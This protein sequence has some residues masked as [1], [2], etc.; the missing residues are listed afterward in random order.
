MVKW[1][2]RLVWRFKRRGVIR[3][4]ADLVRAQLATRGFPECPAHGGSIRCDAADEQVGKLVE[5]IRLEQDWLDSA[6]TQIE[7]KDEVDRIRGRRQHL[8]ER[9]TLLLPMLE[10]VYVDTNEEKRVV[11]IKPKA[12]FSRSSR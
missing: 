12:P 4:L 10:A 7:V 6:L 9:R 3:S 11:A 5:A 8:E 2:V 1:I